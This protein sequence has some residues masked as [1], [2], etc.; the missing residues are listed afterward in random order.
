LWVRKREQKNINNKKT[1]KLQALNKIA[2]CNA[3]GTNK[4]A[5]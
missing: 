5:K 3:R 2:A 4:I 1:R